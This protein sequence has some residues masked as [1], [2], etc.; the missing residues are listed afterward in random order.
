MKSFAA[1]A[2]LVVAAGA[3]AAP[4]KVRAIHAARQVEA[5]VNALKAKQALAKVS[6]CGPEG[7]SIVDIHSDAAGNIRFVYEEVG[8]PETLV[9]LSG[10]YDDKGRRRFVFARAEAKS[11]AALER[12]FYY[13][14]SGALIEKRDKVLKGPD[15]P[16]DWAAVEKDAV[17]GR[18][19]NPGKVQ[20]EF[21]ACPVLD[22]TAG[23]NPQ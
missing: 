4:P 9:R 10:F 11:G 6:H 23:E 16:W 1:A 5:D 18:F 2:L 20:A 15:R 22:E 12:R 7:K 8:G 21:P 14:S 13:A 17:N 3:Q 19:L